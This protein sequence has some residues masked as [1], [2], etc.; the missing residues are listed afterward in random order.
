[1]KNNDNQYV[2]FK[3]EEEFYGININYVQTIEK[4]TEITRVPKTESYIKGVINL[5]GEIVPVI[6]LRKRFN[7]GIKEYD[8]DARIIV[9]KIEDVLIGFIVDSASEVKDINQEDIDY[10]IVDDSFSEGFIKGIGKI[11]DRVIILID[12]YK[13]L[14]MND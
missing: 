12:V 2:I 11:E 10:N 4:M 13:I 8:K 7:L 1:M 14:N 3:L 9:N 5:R 6:D